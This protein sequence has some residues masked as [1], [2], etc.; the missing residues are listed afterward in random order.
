MDEVVGLSRETL[1]ERPSVVFDEI[2]TEASLGEQS[3]SASAL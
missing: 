2:Q 3:R 1:H